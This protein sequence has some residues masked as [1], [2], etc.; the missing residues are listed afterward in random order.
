[1]ET[2]LEIGLSN[3]AVATL[4]AVGALAVSKLWR[5]PAVAHSLWLLVLLKLVTPPLVGI[6]L[7]GS[8]QS[9]VVPALSASELFQSVLLVPEQEPQE[10]PWQT[11]VGN[12]ATVAGSLMVEEPPPVA[13]EL[14]PASEEVA[15][16]EEPSAL[17]AL[18]TSGAWQS[19]LVFAWISG[20]CL[21]LSLAF[22]RVM[23]FHRV[24]RHARR[25]PSAVQAEVRG[26]ARRLGLG[27]CPAV[28]F[29]PGRV[30][31][32]L[33]GMG[34][35]PR[36]LLPDVLWSRL[37]SDQQATLLAHELAHLRRRDHWVRGLEMVV[38]A[39]YWWHPVVWWARHE[40]RRAEEECCDAW[41]VWS[42][43]RAARAYATA[44][45]ETIDY[46]AE[47]HAALPAEASGIGQTHDLKR[48]VTMIMRGSTPRS[49]TRG[50]FL[51]VLGLATVLLPVLPTWAQPPGGGGDRSPD[52]I[53]M[54]AE[55]ERMRADVAQAEAQLRSAQ[56]QLERARAQMSQAQAQ[57]RSPGGQGP[58]QPTRKII[59][60]EADGRVETYELPADQPLPPQLRRVGAS[61]ARGRT[62]RSEETRREAPGQPGAGPQPGGPAGMPSGGMGA[63]AVGQRGGGMGMPG[64]GGGGVMGGMMGG[65]APPMNDPRM[66]NVEQRLEQLMREI[67]SLRRELRSQRSGG[68]GGGGF[69]G[70]GG[71]PGGGPAGGP[72]MG[73]GPVAP[74][75][76]GPGGAGPG[77][78]SNS[79]T[80]SFGIS[81]STG[82]SSG[83]AGF[84]GFGGGGFGGSGFGGSGGGGFG[85]ASGFGGGGSG[86][87]LGGGG[88]SGG[89]G[90]GG[91]GGAGQEGRTGGFGFGTSGPGVNAIRTFGTAPGLTTGEAATPRAGSGET[92]KATPAKPR[93]PEP[94]E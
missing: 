93:T 94:P 7:L 49:L 23:R 31:P 43:P 80:G 33:W 88:G 55:V 81:S 91:L 67:E 84:G 6:P 14:P 21:W 62:A 5:R 70:P 17:L 36:L 61:T 29:V 78:G 41:V 58:N 24:L 75:A 4:L 54:R 48:R 37:N 65:P 42:L 1:M 89:L 3:A 60:I 76:G 90:G 18:V 52:E 87:G 38:T 82:S 72:S 34:G 40:L 46:L 16:A 39:L 92:P 30:S 50:G 63:A 71:G 59:V 19:Y 44:L 51:A 68:G 28:W 86:G 11:L 25:A 22:A 56:A 85:G 64:S 20:S 79:S 73:P 74:G 47:S 26:I 66:Q 10:Q 57:P 2:L 45:V 32:M 27:M 12:A 83:Q 69:G 53:R 35:P 15:P 77:R 9:A 8:P 13:G